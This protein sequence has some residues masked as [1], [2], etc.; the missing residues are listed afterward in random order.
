VERDVKVG[1]A[2]NTKPRS[3]IFRALIFPSILL[4]A[5]LL[6][7]PYYTSSVYI[8][9]KAGR[10]RIVKQVYLIPVSSAEQ[11]RKY[12]SGTLPQP[13]WWSSSDADRSI[14]LGRIHSDNSYARGL[15][16]LQ[17]FQ[18]TSQERMPFADAK[19]WKKFL[20]TLLN[21][22]AMP[23]SRPVSYETAMMFRAEVSAKRSELNR[24]LR[25]D[26]IPRAEDVRRL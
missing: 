1:A 24:P 26:D 6:L 15:T 16:L 5:A 7:I 21:I 20:T 19:A 23:Q 25:S 17:D 12:V 13:E 8:D 22:Y 2:G 11:Y 9:V 18:D 10:M 4:V 3:R 14:L